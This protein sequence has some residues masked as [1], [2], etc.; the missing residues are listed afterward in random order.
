MFRF[1]NPRKHK[2]TFDLLLSGSTKWE[3]LARNG[4]KRFA[5]ETKKQ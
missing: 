1:Y 4:L 5:K 2:K 3:N